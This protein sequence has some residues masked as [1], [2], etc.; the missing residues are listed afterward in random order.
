MIWKI[1]KK[2]KFKFTSEK[3]WKIWKKVKLNSEDMKDMEE[4]QVE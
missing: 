2:S 1:W 3:M 4:T